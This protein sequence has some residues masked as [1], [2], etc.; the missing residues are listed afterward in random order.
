MKAIV[1]L[2][3]VLSLSACGTIGGALTGDGRD[4]QQLGGWVMSK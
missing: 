4:M 1:A 2:L 3:L